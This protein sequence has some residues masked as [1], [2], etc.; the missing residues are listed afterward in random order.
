MVSSC[1]CF[2]CDIQVRT[3]W[4]HQLCTNIGRFMAKSRFISGQ[5]TKEIKR[6]S[7]TYVLLFYDTP[8][9]ISTLSHKGIRNKLF[10]LVNLLSF[11]EPQLAIC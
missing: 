7:Y 11:S 3:V 8:L 10:D 9:T 2:A 1:P 5:S 6:G 4:P